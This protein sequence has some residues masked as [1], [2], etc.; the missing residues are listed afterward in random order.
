M[1]SFPFYRFFV[2]LVLIE[3][4]DVDEKKH[5][6]RAN[7]RGVSACDTKRVEERS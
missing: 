2:K 4:E 5:Y 3:K 7:R 1:L 6:K